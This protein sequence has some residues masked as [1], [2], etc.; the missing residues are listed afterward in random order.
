M[1]KNNL[2]I[3]LRSLLKQKIYTIINVLG[4]A[5]GIASCLLIVLFIQNEFSY[6]KFFQDHDH[7]YRMVLERKYPT[8]STFYSIIPNS[9]EGVIRRN[10]PEVEESTNAFGFQNFSMS[11]KNERDEVSQFDEDFVLAVDSN[12]LKMFSFK[13]LK[14]NP[15][16]VLRQANEMVITQEMSRRYFGE[17]DPIGK[18]ITAGQQEFKIS[19]VIEDVPQNS[20]L[21]FSSLLSVITFPFTARENFISFSSYT[22][23]R[24]KPG[25]D[26]AA[27]EAKIPKV[28]DTYAAAQIE[29]NLG[30]SWADYSKE[31]NGYRYFLQ[32]L[33]SIHLD[34]VNLEAKMKP[35]GNRTS[36][37]IMIS[38]AILI[39]LIACINFM[40]LATARSSERARE[41]GVR[42]VMGSFRQQLVAQFL[43]ESFVL[44]ATGVAL[45]VALIYL[46]LPIFNNLIDKQLTIPVTPTTII[47]LVLLAGFV[48]LL[49]GSYPSLVLSSFNPVVVLKG[50]FTGSHKGKWIRNGLVIFQFWISI[51][52]MIGT[53]VIQQQMKFMSEKSLGFDSDQV[54]VVE[55]GFGLEAPMVKTMIEE[56]KRMPEV[57]SVAGSFAI[58]G[59]ESDYFGI[60]FQPEGSSEILTTKSMVI[61][62]G[63]AEVLGFELV[64]GRW[65]S[66]E[67]ND[68]LN[69]ILNEAA[70]KVMSLENPI[71]RKLI[72]IQERPEGNIAVPFTVVGVVKDFN[73][74][75]LRD[76]VTPL[77][78]QSNEAFGR[79]A[80]YF[81]TRV[82]AGQ[83]PDAIHA[84]ETKWKELV[85]AEPFKFSF[86]DENLDAQYK[87]ER[88]SGKLFAVFSGLAIFVS[89]IG[90]FALSAYIT[91]LR[92]KEIG[93][94]KVLGSSVAGVVILL[95]KDFTKMI[96]IAFILAVPVAWYVMEHWWLQNFAY[97]INISLW[98]ILVSGLSALMIAWITVS[99]QSIK[100]AIQNPVGSLRSE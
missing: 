22:Y 43:T 37:Y 23:F 27:M 25:S 61:A 41:V 96:L 15:D 30:K 100:A 57:V 13:L 14:G 66:E 1:L 47:A 12:F 89:C 70:V 76:K 62:D 11:Y 58:P 49:A 19:G 77:A 16:K 17:V 26:P 4:L 10:F 74:I 82:K 7:I 56:I 98:I 46:L 79:A 84:I 5:V 72:D 35:G 36:V 85:P 65:F 31:G 29:K 3:A 40:N 94:R 97:R 9:F 55:R 45:A 2:K 64:E 8:H 71:G 60:Q 21:K 50:K 48:G 39:L 88:Q 99:Y 24:L 67:M 87:S 51:I 33:A 73:F 93:V 80:Q 34:P 59:R 38:V 75:S 18:I 81:V 6:D 86:L 78:I 95:S 63:L 91:S 44:S 68:S 32:P 20:H 92:T 69:V 54:L 53:L 42:K 52:L 83:I 90:L 28:V